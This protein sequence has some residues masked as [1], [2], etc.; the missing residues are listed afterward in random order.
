MMKN[1]YLIFLIEMRN[2]INPLRGLKYVILN[3]YLQK[4]NLYEVVKNKL[5]T[6]QSTWR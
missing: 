4:Y 6:I 3:I 2:I 1:I 5:H